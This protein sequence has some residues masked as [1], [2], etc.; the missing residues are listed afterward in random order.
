MRHLLALALI[1]SASVGLSAC[2]RPDLIQTDRTQFTP[3]DT[4]QR[5]AFSQPVVLTFDKT[6][7]V[8]REAGYTLDIVDRATGQISGRRGKTGDKGAQR[9][10]DLRFVALILPGAGDVGSVLNLK[11]VQVSPL[12]VPVISRSKAEVVLSQPELYA[13]VFSRIS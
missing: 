4:F 1:A 10:D 6:V 8:F 7:T 9:S 3:D 12:G 11:F 2:A 5:K 13:Y